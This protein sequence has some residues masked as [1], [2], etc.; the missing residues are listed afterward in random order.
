MSCRCCALA[1]AVIL[2][3]SVTVATAAG[4]AAPGRH[5]MHLAESKITRIRPATDV[6]D[7]GGV[8]DDD[9]RDNDNDVA[10]DVGAFAA[11]ATRRF[12]LAAGGHFGQRT[13]PLPMPLQKTHAAKHATSVAGA[14][15]LSNH[16]VLR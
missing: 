13:V 6:N 11:R 10:N 2:H 5:E 15:K 7:V 1:V 16:E 14:K 3:A 9:D 8:D 4:V 12:N